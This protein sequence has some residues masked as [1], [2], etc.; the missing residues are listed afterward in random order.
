ME[1]LPTEPQRPGE[2]ALDADPAR[3]NPIALTGAALLA[4]DAVDGTPLLDSEP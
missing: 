2:V 3:P 4:L 1:L